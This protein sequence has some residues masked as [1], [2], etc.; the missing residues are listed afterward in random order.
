MKWA[1]LIIPLGTYVLGKSIQAIGWSIPHWVDFWGYDFLATPVVCTCAWY[2][3]CAVRRVPCGRVPVPQV[4]ATVLVLS[5]VFEVWLPMQSTRYTAD[6][7]D[8]LMY[9]AGGAC[10]VAVER[11]VIVSR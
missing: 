2:V 4:C 8:A 7:W 11:W 6:A 3:T 10:L 1:V 9:A 5:L